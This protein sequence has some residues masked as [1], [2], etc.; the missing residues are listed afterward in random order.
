MSKPSAGVRQTPLRM[1]LGA[2]LLALAACEGKQAGVVADES[3]V[4]AGAAVSQAAK[5]ADAA[6]VATSCGAAPQ[7]ELV[8]GR[9][10]AANSTRTEP[11]LY[12]GP[13]WLG[14]ALYFSDFTFSAG[15]PSRI[16]K[17][18]ATG[19]MTTAIDDSGSNG[20]A[21]DAEGNLLAGTHKYKSVSRYNLATAERSSVAETFNGQVFNSPNDLV[22]AR[23]GSVYFTDPAFQRDAAPGGQEKT[24]VYRVAVD[25][26]V[27][28]VDDSISNPNGI[29]LSPAQDVLYVNGGGEQGIL[30]AYPLVDGV[31]G[32]GKDL[33]QGLVI[34]DGM[35]V[36][37]HGNIY[38]TEHTAQRL[39]VFTPA[40]EELA[41]IKTDANIT[42]AAFGGATGKTLFLTGAGALWSIDL[43]VTG[44]NY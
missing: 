17:L 18:D 29:T 42:N 21:A 8:A 32:A 10:L 43:A 5:P 19:T 1:T 30:R 7:G 37:C 33:V 26:T 6:A 11:G 23:D 36:D 35:A 34:P 25:G 38:V 12:E 40:G 22:V 28:L 16:Q 15:F 39:R 31:P 44:S 2:L 14:D 20:L 27:T 13:V 24:G 4:G 3:S 41:V 9:I